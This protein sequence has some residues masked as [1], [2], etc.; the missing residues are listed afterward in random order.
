L[1]VGC[2]AEE[3]PLNKKSIVATSKKMK[4]GSNLV[5]SSKEGCSSKIAV[6]PMKMMIT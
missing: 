4:T 6:S 5:E 3:L 2:K 1:E